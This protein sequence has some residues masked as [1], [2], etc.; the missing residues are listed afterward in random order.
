LGHIGQGDTLT[1]NNECLNQ[2]DYVMKYRE[3]ICSEQRSRYKLDFAR[4]LPEYQKL[5]LHCDSVAKK[6]QALEERLKSSQ[7]GSDEWN[8]V[9]EKIMADYEDLKKDTRFE[10]AKRR[11]I[12]L[13]D[14]LTHIKSLINAYDSNI[15][16][17]KSRSSAPSKR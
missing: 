11:A 9:M 3:I 4:E 13:H 5:H 7:E 14:K 15:G 10:S 12:Y 17:G 6:F 2:A 8:R 1:P 16:G